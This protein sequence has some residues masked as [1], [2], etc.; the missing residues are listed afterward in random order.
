[1]AEEI[2]MLDYHEIIILELKKIRWVKNADYYPENKAQLMTPSI[3]LTIDG[4]MP[5]SDNGQ[6]ICEVSSHL[7][8]VSDKSSENEDIPNPTVYAAQLAADVTQWVHGQGFSIREAQP[9]KFENAEI[10]ELDPSLDE[11][12]VWRIDFSQ[13]IP[14]GLDSTKEKSY[15]PLKG[16]YLGAAPE[17]GLGNEDKYIPIGKLLDD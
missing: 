12:L 10:D 9:A 17:I 8:I 3:Y 5:Y 2:L 4:W 7:F 14:F 13:K 6:L 15:G 16:V 1:M 11:Y